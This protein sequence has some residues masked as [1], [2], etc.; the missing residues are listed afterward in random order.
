M[1]GIGYMEIIV[2]LVVMLIVL[3]PERMPVVVK[4]IARFIREVR[5]V[6]S[7]ARAQLEDA[8]DVDEFRGV[9]ED[10]RRSVRDAVKQGDVN[11]AVRD[12][13]RPPANAKPEPA[14][15]DADEAETEEEAVE[16]PKEMTE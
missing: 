7:E 15:T 3:G 4:S 9:A 5:A 10:A 6:A 16:P 13:L 11:G 12:A 14:K 1:I 2:A 8:V